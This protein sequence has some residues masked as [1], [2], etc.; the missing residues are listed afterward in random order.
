WPWS[1]PFFA[2]VT[3]RCS[4]I[5]SSSV[6]RVSTAN[7]RCSPSTRSVMLAFTKTPP[8]LAGRTERSHRPGSRVGG[9]Q[10]EPA[11]RRIEAHGARRQGGPDRRRRHEGVGIDLA[12][13][14]QRAVPAIGAEDQLARRIKRRG[15]G[16][17]PYRQSRHC[18]ATVSV[19]DDEALIL[20]ARE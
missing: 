2:A 7:E 19:D 14:R 11:A 13:D 6:V 15:V 17:L 16:A 12:N 4:R 18:S 1:Q 3:P 20:T 9:H 8:G 10:K 5:A